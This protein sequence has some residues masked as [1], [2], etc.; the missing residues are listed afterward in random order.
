MHGDSGPVD[1]FAE[2]PR[3]ALKSEGRVEI[4]RKRPVL[5]KGSI[6]IIGYGDTKKQREDYFDYTYHDPG[7][8]KAF[9]CDFRWCRHCDLLGSRSRRRSK[10]GTFKF[11]K[12]SSNVNVSISQVSEPGFEIF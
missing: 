7:A 2:E 1:N 10:M 8:V 5:E 12:R 6:K 4:I 9:H 3:N 11:G